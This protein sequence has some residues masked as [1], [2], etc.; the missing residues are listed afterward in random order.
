MKR[1]KYGIVCSA[2][3]LLIGA[4]F[5][6]LAVNITD[7]TGDVWHWSN[8]GTGTAYSWTGNVGNKPNID[9]TQVSATVNGNNLTM[10][11]TVAGTIQYS[12]K[13]MYWAYYNTTDTTYSM[14]WYNGTGFGIASK[15]GGGGYEYAENLTVSGNTLSAIFK[16]LGNTSKVEQWGSAAEY[17][18]M[19]ANQTTNEWWGDWAPNSKI[20]FSTTPGGNTGGNNTG[21]NNTGGNTTGKKTPGFELLPVIAGIAI[22]AILFRRRQ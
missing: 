11:L 22:A 4:S 12:A 6:A 13:V 3:F 21:G 2:L 1:W 19:G 18:T 17:T 9:I 14:G 8:T 7:P 15:P 20:P 16:V 5:T 10:S